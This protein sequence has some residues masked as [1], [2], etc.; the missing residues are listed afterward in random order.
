MKYSTWQLFIEFYDSE[1]QWKVAGGDINLPIQVSLQ[2][3][4]N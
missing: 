4:I 2:P 1:A 3:W